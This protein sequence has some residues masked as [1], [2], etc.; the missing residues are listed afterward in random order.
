MQVSVTQ[1][2]NLA[3][4][5]LYPFSLF[6][7][8]LP[9]H[10]ASFLHLSILPICQWSTH[11]HI[12]A[13]AHTHTHTHAHSHTHTHTHTQ[14]LGVLARYHAEGADDMVLEHCCFTVVTLFLH[15][16]YTVV[17]LLLHCCYTVAT[18]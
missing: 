6:L 14:D 11:T 1:I 8:P 18:L 12:H 4:V 9:P 10:L 16:C 2:N 3:T 15:C 17:T 7:P 5:P 13:H